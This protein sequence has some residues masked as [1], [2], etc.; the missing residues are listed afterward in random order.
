MKTIRWQCLECKTCSLCGES[1]KEVRS[2][3]GFKAFL[4]GCNGGLRV[5]CAAHLNEIERF[6]YLLITVV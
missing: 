4:I 5:R 1:S 3:V 2:P 6:C